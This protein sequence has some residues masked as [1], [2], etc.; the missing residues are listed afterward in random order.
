M[1]GCGSVAT[2]RV[3]WLGHL[4]ALMARRVMVMAM[5][6]ARGST[7]TRPRSCRPATCRASAASSVAILASS[8][9]PAACARVGGGGVA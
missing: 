7:V 9:E 5:P 8:D 1:L 6:V 2:L 3:P 4:E